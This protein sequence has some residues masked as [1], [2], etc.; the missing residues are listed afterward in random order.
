[1]LLTPAPL[2]PL[3]SE[4]Y[5][6]DGVE[7]RFSKVLGVPTPGGLKPYIVRMGLGYSE[8]ANIR[9]PQLPALPWGSIVEIQGEPQVSQLVLELAKAGYY[10]MLHLG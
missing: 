4:L 10:Q 7:P 9:R 6:G 2:L 5:Y 3:N 8:V 1:M